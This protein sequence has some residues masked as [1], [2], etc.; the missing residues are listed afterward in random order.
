MIEKYLFFEISNCILISISEKVQ[1]TMPSM[2]IFQMIHHVRSVTLRKIKHSKNNGPHSETNL[3]MKTLKVFFYGL[4]HELWNSDLLN[5]CHLAVLETKD[6]LNLPFTV[7]LVTLSNKCQRKTFIVAKL[8]RVQ[9]FHN[10][11][12]I[13]HSVTPKHSIA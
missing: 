7:D 10:S 5:Q 2:I 4:C 13:L 11:L 1:Y 9:F 12:S 8:T 3:K 6:I